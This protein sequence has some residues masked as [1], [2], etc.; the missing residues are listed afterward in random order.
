MV[1]MTERECN[2]LSFQHQDTPWIPSWLTGH[3]TCF[4]T[5]IEEGARGYG[6]TTDWFGV[7][8]L[9]RE[10]QPGPMPVESDP[11]ITDIENWRDQVI[12]P[13]LDAYD[14]EGCAA[15]DTA[16]WDRENK[17]SNV[18]LVNGIF[19]SLHMFCGFEEA[20]CNIMEDEEAC[21]DFMGWMADYKI[22]VIERLAKYYKPDMIQFHDDYSNGTDLFMPASKW[23][24]MIRPHL[25]R[26]VDCVHD[27][28][29]IYQHH[30]CGKIHDLIP[31]LVD[32]GI[33]ALNPVQI[34]NNPLEVKQQWGDKLTVCGGFDNQNY[35]DNPDATDEQ[36]RD[37]INE[38]L[39]T[40]GPGGKYNAFCYILDRFPER[41]GI[42]LQC[43]DEY[44][45]P[46]MEREG[47]E[48]VSHTG[49]E[50]QNVYNLAENAAN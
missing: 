49:G 21:S 23:E 17:I 43:L 6:I 5:V 8:Y 19:E 24:R 37:S 28:G 44:N 32:V 48:F 29:M 33:D 36:I 45:R 16:S 27:N 3:D 20:L 26:I 30:S 10:D 46:L 2:L 47:V 25:Q 31:N 22:A 15:S 42:F 9:Y 11:K 12:M 7:K 18:V 39:H 38:T 4:P 34:S 1:K 14:W 40:L 41:Y 13:D 50:V 35:L